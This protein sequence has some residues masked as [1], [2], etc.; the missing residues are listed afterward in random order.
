MADKEAVVTEEPKRFV[1]K[2][3]FRDDRVT[4]DK[5]SVT[6]YPDGS[7]S[8]EGHKMAEFSHNTW[9]TDSAEDAEKLRVTIQ[10]RLK[11]APLG[12][13]ET[14]DIDAPSKAGSKAGKKV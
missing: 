5:P 13:I 4:L 10:K 12:I 6:Q 3:K 14:T 8:V 1:F 7:K 11:R 2:S 9:S